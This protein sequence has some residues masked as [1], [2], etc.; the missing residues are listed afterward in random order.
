MSHH[1][2][3]W[4][5]AQQRARDYLAEAERERLARLAAPPRSLRTRAATAL[6]AIAARLDPHSE[7]AAGRLAP[8]R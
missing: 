8:A 2:S 6:R 5:L 7:P 4:F 3:H 1:P